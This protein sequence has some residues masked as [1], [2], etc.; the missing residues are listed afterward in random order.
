MNLYEYTYNLVR[1]IPDGMISSYGAIA[2]ALGDIRASRAVGRMMNQNPDADDMPCFKIVYSNGKI[3]GFG[4]GIDD[5]IRRLRLDDIEVKDNRII[6]F[7][8][9]F[10]NDFATNFPLKKLRKKQIELSKKVKVVDNFDKIDTVAGFDVGYPKN[11]FE[12]CCAACIVMDYKTKK[13]IEEKLIYD[14]IFFPYIPTYLTFRESNFITL[15]Y[16]KLD[17]K[18]DILMIDGN[19][20]LHPFGLGIASYIGV[21]MNI[22]TIGVAKNMLCGKLE[23]DKV[24]LDDKI[25]GCT[26]FS[27]RLIKKPLFISPGHKITLDKS[28]SVVKNFCIHKI[29]EPIRK[30]HLLATENI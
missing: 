28:L 5:K 13:I 15:L 11:D 2:E 26:Y 25:I 9:V 24:L 27:S 16:N 7:K 22:P 6:N 8:K 17:I 21:E 30:A 14:K 18:P 23:N 3:G 19:G 29:P 12:N 20:I 10:F 4:L 1:Q